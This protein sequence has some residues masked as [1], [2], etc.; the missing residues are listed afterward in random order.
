LAVPE[1]WHRFLRSDQITPRTRSTTK[2][3]NAATDILD[4][5]KMSAEFLAT[6]AVAAAGGT[7]AVVT[8]EG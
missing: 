6:A 2:N 1:N 4:V 3:G 8:E 5:E 7:G